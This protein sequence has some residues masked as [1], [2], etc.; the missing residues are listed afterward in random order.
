MQTL[1]RPNQNPR[2]IIIQ[3]LYGKFNVDL[4]QFFPKQVPVEP[5]SMNPNPVV[6]PKPTAQVI[7]QTGLTQTE[8]ALLSPEE[9][10]IRQRART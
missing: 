6:Q 5:Q 4:E 10:I 9:Q 3:N 7:P 8:T 1:Y 2:V